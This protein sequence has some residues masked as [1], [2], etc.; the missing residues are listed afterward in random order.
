MPKVQNVGEFEFRCSTTKDCKDSNIRT[1]KAIIVDLPIEEQ[2]TIGCA[3]CPTQPTLQKGH[4][5]S[6]VCSTISMPNAAPLQLTEPEKA[7]QLLRTSN[8]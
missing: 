6:Y 2:L 7:T 3:L 8:A 5:E 1:K 4:L